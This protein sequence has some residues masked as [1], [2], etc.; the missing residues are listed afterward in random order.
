M[1][2]GNKS[3]MEI[4]TVTDIHTGEVLDREMKYDIIEDKTYGVF[5]SLKDGYDVFKV[6]LYDMPTRL[7][8]YFDNIYHSIFDG[9]DTKYKKWVE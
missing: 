4:K 9:L 6:K 1:V 5:H 3:H 8:S 2:E 7:H